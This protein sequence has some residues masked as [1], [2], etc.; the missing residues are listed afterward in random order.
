MIRHI[1]KPE[2]RHFKLLRYPVFDK[3]MPR[4]MRSFL[5]KFIVAKNEF[6]SAK[7]HFR[8]HAYL[9]NKKDGTI[10][11]GCRYCQERLVNDV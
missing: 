9:Y 1:L 6:V 8:Y 2:N 5:N 11:D 10:Y 4:N 3:P 7:L